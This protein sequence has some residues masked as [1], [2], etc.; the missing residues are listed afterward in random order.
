[1][2]N[3]LIPSVMNIGTWTKIK[4]LNFFPY[5]TDPSKLALPQ[6]FFHDF[7]IEKYFFIILKF[8]L[9]SFEAFLVLCSFSYHYTPGIYAEG[10]IV[11]AVLF[12]H[13]V[14]S[15]VRTSVSFVEFTTKF[16]TKLRESFSSGVY[17]TNYSSESIQIWTISTLEGLLPCHEFWPQGSCSG[18]GVGLE[19]KI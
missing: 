2:Y 13:F 1:M 19:V 11:F 15:Y 17:L 18:V 8:M 14:R 10:Y 6:I 3:I 9:C 7:R 16:S 12:F 4:T 5:P